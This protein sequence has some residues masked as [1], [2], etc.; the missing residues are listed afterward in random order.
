M[1]TRRV[2][3]VIRN[4]PFVAIS[5]HSSVR[6]AACLM[7]AYK[8]SAVMVVN[9]K[10]MLRGICTERDIVHGLVSKGMDPD[11]VQVGTIMT[12]HPRT[13]SADRPFG[14]ALH[15]MFEGGFRHVPVVDIVGRPI[16][17]LSSHDALDSD[18]LEFGR[19]LE[20]REEITVI[21]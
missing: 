3:E 15:M 9:N 13:V 1:P 19:E 18:A 4:K 12:G 7:E 14:H 21:L 2:S 6:E 16:G 11:Q 20:W 10:K 17:I 8:T 5:A